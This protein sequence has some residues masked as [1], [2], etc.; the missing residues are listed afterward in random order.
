MSKTYKIQLNDDIFECNENSDIMREICKQRIG[1]KFHGCC[2]GGCGVCKASVIS[3]QYKIVSRMSRAHVSEAEEE[4][5]IVL[6]CC[7]QPQSDLIIQF[8]K[9]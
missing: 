2:G 8:L 1:Y 4:A 9:D 6:L 3:G 5:G 7:I